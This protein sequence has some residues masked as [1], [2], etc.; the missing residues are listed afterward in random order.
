MKK[1]YTL[2]S[3]MCIAALGFSQY[4]YI[5]YVN[6]N[7]NPGN[8]NQDTDSEYPVGGGLNGAWTVIQ[9]PSASA[10]SPNQTIPF[11]F[12]F[13]G[14]P[15]TQY[16]VSTTGVLT[17]TTSAVTVPGTPS[18]LPSA[19]LP[20]ASVCAWGISGS[21]SNDNIVK[22]TYGTAPNR[23]EWISFSSYT[24]GANWT[25][26]SIVLEETTNNIYSRPKTF[27]FL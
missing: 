12:S 20:D 9:G 21:G 15:V 26:F 8:I 25:Y 16:K 4:Y 19:S 1:L 23:Q 17:F 10:W 13:N 18:A 2:V 3:M 22:R 6:A 14:S 24:N 11:T 27:F 5:P 7:Q